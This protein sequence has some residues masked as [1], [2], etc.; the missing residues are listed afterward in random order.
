MAAF[1]FLMQMQDRIFYDD[2]LV[3]DIFDV[4]GNETDDIDNAF[5][6]VALLPDGRW[7]TSECLYKDLI[8]KK[9][10]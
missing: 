8:R 5:S 10:H 3:T 7:L 6:F 1:T 4:Y 2:L 9:L